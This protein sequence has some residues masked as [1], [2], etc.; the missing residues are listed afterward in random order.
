MKSQF[1]LIALLATFSAFGQQTLNDSLLVDGIYRHFITYIPST[2][3]QSQATPLVFNFHG[4]TS[5]AQAKMWYGD[6]RNIADTANFILVHPQGLLDNTGV[7]HWNIGQSTVDDIGFINAL[8]QYVL[9]NYNI[10]I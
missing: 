9:S 7:T 2:Y 5:S 3:Q 1:L 4:R 6:F 8:Y 10:D